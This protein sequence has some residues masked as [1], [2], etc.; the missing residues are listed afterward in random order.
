A[1][2]GRR[3]TLSCRAAVQQSTRQGVATTRIDRDHK[4]EEE[5]RMKRVLFGLTMGAAAVLAAGC[6]Q[7]GKSPSAAP[8]A[9]TAA[10][11]APGATR[12]AAP[13]TPKSGTNTSGRVTF[14]QQ[15]GG[16]MVVVAV[17]GL[18]PGTTH[19]F[20]IHE[21]GD[22]SAPDAMSAG[23][24]FNPG[25]KPHGQMSMADHHAGALDRRARLEPA[26]VVELRG[27]RVG[28][29]ERQAAHVPGLQRQEQQGRKA[30]HHEQPHPVVERIFLH[31]SL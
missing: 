2:M 15:Q 21:K 3:P 24:H 1:K 10:A 17:T 26:D 23:G 30:Q 9:A 12:A 11:A 27:H 29:L 31:A 19:G 22:C 8:M 25:G 5:E 16:V 18:P 28:F 20:H 14:D 13:L 6:S 7:P 4:Q